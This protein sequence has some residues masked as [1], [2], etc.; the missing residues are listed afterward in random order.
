MELQ[1]GETCFEPEAGRI[2]LYLPVHSALFI[3][4]LQLSYVRAVS[5]HIKPAK[6][7]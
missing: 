2:N 5:S 1:I 6:V 3:L 4:F 7:I